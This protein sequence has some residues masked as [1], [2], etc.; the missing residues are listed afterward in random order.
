MVFP[1]VC[2]MPSAV[3][4]SISFNCREA[5]QSQ[6]AALMTVMATQ[7]NPADH[8]KLQEPFQ[9]AAES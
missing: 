6:A 3:L 1:V 4:P 8:N 7:E 5:A 2:V 9:D